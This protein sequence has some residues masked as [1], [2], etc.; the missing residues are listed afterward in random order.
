[1]PMSD[2]VD[3]ET[4]IAIARAIVAGK[5]SGTE[6]LPVNTQI[7]ALARTIVYMAEERERNA[8]PLP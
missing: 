7:K 2:G 5:P 8:L 4:M 1:M 3:L 6:H